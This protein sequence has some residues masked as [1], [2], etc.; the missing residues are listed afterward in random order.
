MAGTLAAIVAFLGQHRGE[1]FCSDCIAFS[2]NR[3]LQEIRA[4]LMALAQ[5]IV[6]DTVV[7][8][9]AM[10]RQRMVTHSVRHSDAA[11]DLLVHTF[12]MIPGGQLRTAG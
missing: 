11:D 2:M 8:T 12:A 1:Y 6:I 5:E 7:G 10:C 9:C 3:G 4:A